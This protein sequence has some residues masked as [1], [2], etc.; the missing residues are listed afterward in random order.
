MTAKSTSVTHYLITNRLVEVKNGKEVIRSDG[1][2]EAQDELRYGR[3]TFDPSKKKP[4]FDIDL[5]EDLTEEEAKTYYE[6]GQLPTGKQLGSHVLFEDLYTK[7]VNVEPNEAADVLVFV[8]GFKSDL[9]GTLE[10][11][12]ELHEKYVMHPDSPIKHIIMFTWPARSNVLR[13]RDDARDAVKSGYALARSYQFLKSIYQEVFAGR[14]HRRPLCKQRM[15]LMCHSMGNRVLES[16]FRE[17][18]FQ[19]I[20]INTIFSQVFLVGADIDWDALEQPNPLYALTDICE[21]A[22]VYF[23]RNDQALGVSE[24]TKNEFN[25]LGRWGAKNSSRLADDIFQS[26]VSDIGDDDKLINEIIH[27]WY[28]YNSPTVVNDIVAVMNGNFSFFAV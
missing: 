20:Q 25:R 18:M 14:R 15:H 13:Y 11:L 9:D 2:E 27:H 6:T 22:H 5:F 17:L 1:K 19:H 24:H 26:D 10:T 3:V 16:M 12:H 7:M 4:N 21:R 8:H 23:H 28:Y